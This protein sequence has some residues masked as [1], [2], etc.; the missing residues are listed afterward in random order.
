MDRVTLQELAFAMPRTSPAIP[1]G[2]YRF[3]DREYFII[4]D[5]TTGQVIAVA[6][7]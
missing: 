6:G 5:R 2:P 3:V 1:P 4:R 7:G